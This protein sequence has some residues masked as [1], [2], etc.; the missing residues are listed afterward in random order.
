MSYMVVSPKALRAIEAKERQEERL[1]EMERRIAHLEEFMKRLLR[2][3]TDA[4]ERKA[5][6]NPDA[7]HEGMGDAPTEEY[8]K[9]MADPER[10]YP[11][12]PHARVS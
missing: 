10:K 5:G 12:V 4:A 1:A 8:L 2:D 9:A 11:L 7:R 3:R 6:G